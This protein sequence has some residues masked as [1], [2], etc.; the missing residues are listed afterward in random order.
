ML[1]MREEII[2]ALLP[3]PG[4]RSLEGATLILEEIRGSMLIERLGI[5]LGTLLCQGFGGRGACLWNLEI[6]WRY[7]AH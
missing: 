6:P 1:R 7:Y 4:F 2:C 5:D 3:T